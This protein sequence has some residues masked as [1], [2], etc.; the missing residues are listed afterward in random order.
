[1]ILACIHPGF[2]S[3]SHDQVLNSH[4]S[5][6]VTI[7]EAE[8]RWRDWT[9][10]SSRQKTQMKMGGLLG[11]IRL[12]GEQIEPFWPVIQLGQWVH[13]GKGSVMGLGKYRIDGSLDK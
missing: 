7:Q 8:L 4:S 11:S 9:R 2:H 12:P 6:R 10:Y 5:R 13:A 1:M 3:R